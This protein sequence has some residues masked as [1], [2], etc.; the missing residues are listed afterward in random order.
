EFHADASTVSMLWNSGDSIQRIDAID[1]ARHRLDW[2]S[3]LRLLGRFEQ[4]GEFASAATLALLGRAF[5]EDID[6]S[7]QDALLVERLVDPKRALSAA[8]A[9][10]RLPESARTEVVQRLLSDQRK[11]GIDPSARQMLELALQA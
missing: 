3:A 8:S 5:R 11:R 6:V 1:A 7:I 10:A 2:P 9:L 4:Q